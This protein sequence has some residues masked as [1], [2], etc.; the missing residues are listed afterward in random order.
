[1]P[2]EKTEEVVFK[3][4]K[5]GTHELRWNTPLDKEKGFVPRFIDFLKPDESEVS[6][7]VMQDRA[8]SLGAD[9]GQQH[10]EYLLEHQELIPAEFQGKHYLV[11]PGT[12]WFHKSS[13]CNYYVP[14]LE[15]CGGGWFLELKWINPGSSFKG[16]LVGRK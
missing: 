4:D 16:R 9:C 14:C 1:M 2:N 13:G 12:G 5:S 3:Y 6:G 15:W 7:R 8:E 10:A 11:F